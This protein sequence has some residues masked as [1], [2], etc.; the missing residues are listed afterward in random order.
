MA[1]T[2]HSAESCLLY[3]FRTGVFVHACKMFYLEVFVVIVNIQL[4]Q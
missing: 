3:A 4:T 2:G 1:S